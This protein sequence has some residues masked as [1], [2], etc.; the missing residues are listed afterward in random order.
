[1]KIA[2]RFYVAAMLAI[3]VTT[4]FAQGTNDDIFKQKVADA[5]GKYKAGN[6]TG[7][8]ADFMALYNENQ[9]N[10]DVDS[11]IGF[12]HLRNKDAK[13]AIPF[14]E[15]AKALNPKDLE[16]LNNLGNAYLM[17]GQNARALGAY[18]E[19]IKLDGKRFQAYYN[20]GNIQL[21]DHKYGAAEES[22]NMA[23]SLQKDSPQVLNNLGVAQEAQNKVKESFA[24][25]RKASDQKP[26][27]GT[28]ARNAGASAYRLKNYADTVTYLERAMSVRVQDSKMILALADSYGKMGRNDK[29]M[30]LYEKHKDAFDGDFNYYFNLG[31]MK[32]STGDMDGAEVAFRKANML[33]GKNGEARQNLG[34]ILFMKRSYEE[35]K[36]F[37]EP[38]DGDGGVSS[39]LEGKR[40]L[41]AAASRMGDYRTA[42]PLWSEILKMDS[43]DHEVRLLLADAMFN[44]GDTK[45]SLGMY[46]EILAAKSNSAA[47]MDGIGRC[48]LRGASYAAAEASFRSAIKADKSFVPAYNNLA[49]VLE[50][51]NKRKDAI[52]LLEKAASMDENNSDVQKNLKRMRAAG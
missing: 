51:M 52:A 6:S 16:V 26:K 39:T 23:L 7:A 28:Y 14:L 50:K 29:M 19:L 31:V 25:F 47:A 43:N 48:H 35:A 34:V 27:E 9:K 20:I 41:A 22:Y 32:K 38:M 24:S 36:S 30:E 44:S 42:M 33:N 2:M 21:E 5:A 12:L 13:Q 40:N 37:F 15:Q 17:A 49:V 11:W 45:V 3:A 4:A 10:A 18:K 46:K 8:L 1:M